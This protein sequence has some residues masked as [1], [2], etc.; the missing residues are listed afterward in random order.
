MFSALINLKYSQFIWGARVLSEGVKM[1]NEVR[2]GDDDRDKSLA[3]SL[4]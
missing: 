4:R 1:V 3:H 2:D